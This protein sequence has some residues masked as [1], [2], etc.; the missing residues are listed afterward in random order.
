M[1]G[2][3]LEVLGILVHAQVGFSGDRALQFCASCDVVCSSAR[4]WSGNRPKACRPFDRQRTAVQRR[5]RRWQRTV[6]CVVNVDPGSGAERDRLNADKRSGAWAEVHHQVGSTGRVVSTP[7]SP[8]TQAGP[9]LGPASYV[10]PG[11]GRGCSLPSVSGGSEGSGPERQ[12]HLAFGCRTFPRTQ[13]DDRRT[14]RRVASVSE[15]RKGRST[16][17]PR[18][19]PVVVSRGGRAR[20]PWWL[21]A[22]QSTRIARVV[23]EGGEPEREPCSRRAAE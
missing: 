1:I 15:H 14:A 4:A 21:L 19:R 23:P 22:H 8:S 20:S 17:S 16:R 3:W 12:L 9:G 5:H 7:G 11:F 13:G 6:E 18:C 10:P 2:K